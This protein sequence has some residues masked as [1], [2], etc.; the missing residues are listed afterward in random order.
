MLARKNFAT[1]RL[2]WGINTLLCYTT[3]NPFSIDVKI[4][5]L[6]SVL[7]CK[8]PGHSEQISLFARFVDD[9]WLF[10]DKAVLLCRLTTIVAGAS[11]SFTREQLPLPKDLARQA[12]S[13]V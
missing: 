11:F 3:P 9:L 5:I 12:I 2:S 4:E 8:F 6:A 7:K 10:C 13:E 1:L